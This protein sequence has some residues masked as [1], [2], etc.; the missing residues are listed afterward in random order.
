M[1]DEIKNVKY[2]LVVEWSAEDGQWLGLCPEL[3]HGGVHGPDR[4][5][6]FRE[7]CEVVDEVLKDAEASG[8]PLRAPVAPQKHRVDAA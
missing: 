8:I 2:S 6:V 1:N 3:F 4:E 7:L 5:T